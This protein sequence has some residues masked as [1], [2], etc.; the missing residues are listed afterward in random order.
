MSEP[1]FFTLE[2]IL[3]IHQQEIQTSGGD[4]TIRDRE[5][6]R[7]VLM[8]QKRVLVGTFF[9]TYSEWQQA[10]LPVLQYNIH[11]WMGISEQH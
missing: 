11:S 9:M 10:I 3:F 4:P 5:G 6:S 7:L 8:R 2:E 1:S